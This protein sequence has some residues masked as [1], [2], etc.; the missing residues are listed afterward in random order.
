MLYISPFYSGCPSKINCIFGRFSQR[1]DR[2]NGCFYAGDVKVL[3]SSGIKTGRIKVDNQKEKKNKI[4][5]E[6]DWVLF[7]EDTRHD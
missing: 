6:K 5:S 3:M 1:G 4:F 7:S 2:G